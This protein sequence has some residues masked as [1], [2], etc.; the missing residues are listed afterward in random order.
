[1]NKETFCAALELSCVRQ[2]HSVEEI[3]AMAALALECRGAAAFSMP[4]HGALLAEL[5]KGQSEVKPGAV[6][7]FPAGEEL[8]GEKRYQ[9]ERLL[10]AGCREFDM[11]MNLSWLAD[12]KTEKIVEEIRAVKGTVGEHT[13]KVIVEASLLTDEELRRACEA[14]ILG[15]ADYVKTGTGWH[16]P[17]SCDMIRKI[18]GYVK[19]E[20]RIKAAGGLREKSVIEEMCRLGC[21]RFGI[22]VSPARALLDAWEKG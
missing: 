4:A 21:H 16:G 1:M 22:G 12:G 20:V 15:G 18:K 19:D 8:P 11:V 17:A 7:G 14:V 6:I 2:K 13:L 3:K 9:A 10:A 5:L